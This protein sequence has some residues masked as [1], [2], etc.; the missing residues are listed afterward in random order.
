MLVGD[1]NRHA[2]IEHFL[3][4]DPSSSDNEPQVQF[5]HNPVQLIQNTLIQESSKF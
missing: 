1:R 3:P 2:A 4:I 5:A